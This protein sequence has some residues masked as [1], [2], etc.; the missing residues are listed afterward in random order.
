[1]LLSSSGGRFVFQA[2]GQNQKG[3]ALP[4]VSICTFMKPSPFIA[5]TP[6][7]RR[8]RKTAHFKTPD[9]AGC[10]DGYTD[11]TNQLVEKREHQLSGNVLQ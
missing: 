9:F 10:M 4:D 1:M 6:S 8:R 2:V 3:A 7:T 5:P 11:V